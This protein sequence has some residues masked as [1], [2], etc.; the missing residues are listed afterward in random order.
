MVISH[1]IVLAVDVNKSL[2]LP[3][4]FS[5]DLC[6]PDLDTSAPRWCPK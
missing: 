4:L 1:G 2:T 3:I 6:H 5:Y